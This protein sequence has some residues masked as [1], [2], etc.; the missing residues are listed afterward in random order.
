LRNNRGV[1]QFERVG[2]R[3]QRGQRGKKRQRPLQTSGSSSLASVLSD[4]VLHE[5]L[6]A[7]RDAIM[8]RVSMKIDLARPRR[9]TGA[10]LADGIAL[11]FDQLIVIL[12]IPGT[13]SDALTES[14][15]K[16]GRRLLERGFTVA[17][18]VHHYGDVCQAVTEL[19]DETR[20]SIS[21]A[22][23]NTFN[24][25]LD[26][27]IAQAVTAYGRQ[28]ERSLSDHET[29]RIGIFAHELRG[30]IGSAMLSFQTIQ[31]G[32][33]GFGGS[34]AAVLERSLR[35]LAE[36]I[37]SSVAETRLEAGLRTP[38]RVSIR[39]FID[40]FE[41]GASMQ[42]AARGVSFAVAPVETGIEVEADRVLLATAVSNLLQNAFK[43]TRPRG[44][45]SLSAAATA[46]HV[47]IDVEDECGG[48]PPGEA[49]GLFQRFEQRDRDRTGLGLGLWISRR[50]VEANGG[51]IHVR[52]KPGVGCVFTID[53]PRL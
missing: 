40:E 11:F 34:T 26:D 44:H 25:C 49:D 3:C 13:S 1:L 45:V 31:S 51:Q 6:T 24:R 16:H 27:A 38:E 18:V 12:R 37:D 17:Q 21:A 28:R 10:E 7:N 43:F 41:V 52:D 5:F 23:F 15:A 2:G 47:F 22:E 32:T 48:L 8:A 36:L 4:C 30:S 20:T 46:G 19:A 53:L 50:S 33:V 42:A 39:K 35:R 14:A 29:E 9:T